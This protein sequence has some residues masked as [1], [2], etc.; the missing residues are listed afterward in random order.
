MRLRTFQLEFLKRALAPGVDTAALCLPR[1][2][3]TEGNTDVIPAGK[4]NLDAV[5]NQ[6]DDIH[7]QIAHSEGDI[8]AVVGVLGAGNDSLR[9]TLP[10]NLNGVYDV[11]VRVK[12]KVQINE[13]VNFSGNLH[14]TVDGGLG[15]NAEIP[16]KTHNYHNTHDAVLNFLRKGLAIS[17]G[18]SHIDFSTLVT[19]SNPPDSRFIEVENMTI[20][21]TSLVNASNVNPFIA[22]WAEDGNTQEIPDDKLGA[23]RIWARDAADEHQTPTMLE[24]G[25]FLQTDIDV[26]PNGGEQAFSYA[27][28]V[29]K[30]MDGTLAY[31]GGGWTKA[32]AGGGEA[33]S[34]YWLAQAIGPFTADTAKDA[35]TIMQFPGAGY[36]DY[37]ALRAAVLDESVAQVIIR[38]SETDTGGSDDDGATFIVP[39]ILGFH[40]GAAGSYRAFPAWNLG[41]DPVKFGNYIEK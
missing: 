37:A 24:L 29:Q 34:W 8:T 35:T 25:R 2:N 7:E 39:N 18:A 32:A 9:Y 3:G 21:N 27:G 22:D 33:A 23:V 13:L 4:V 15:L 19:G 40:H 28:T 36:A 17:P 31:I 30:D 1:G 20:T 10:V 14:I 11:S 5:Q 26:I 16:E 38:I 6:I 12:A 41:V